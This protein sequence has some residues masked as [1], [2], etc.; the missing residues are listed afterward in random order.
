MEPP[1]MT[2]AQN[3]ALPVREAAV[4]PEV[5]APLTFEA[6]YAQH[7]AFVWRTARQL[8]VELSQLDDVVQDTFLVVHRRFRDFEHRAHVRTWLF[9]ILR[10]VIADHRRTRRRR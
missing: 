1:P 3:G 10:K 4:I 7:F 6:L 5:A 8:G 2:I 9:A